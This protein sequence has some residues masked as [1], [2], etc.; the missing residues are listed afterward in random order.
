VI[1]LSRE[2]AGWKVDGVENDWHQPGS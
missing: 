2:G 1:T